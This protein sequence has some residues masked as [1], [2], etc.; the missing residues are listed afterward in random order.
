MDDMA[1]RG[2]KL[3]DIDG[4]SDIASLIFPPLTHTLTY[5]F[6]CVPL[7]CLP[8]F[9][10]LL[11]SLLHWL[12]LFGSGSLPFLFSSFIISHLPI[13]CLIMPLWALI[14]SYS[15]VFWLLCT[16]IACSTPL[17][18]SVPAAASVLV[19]THRHADSC[20]HSTTSNSHYF[21]WRTRLKDICQQTTTPQ[22]IDTSTYYMR[23]L[24]SV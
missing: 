7:I 12:I 17:F 13:P 24:K 23:R 11:F 4:Q 6:L 15:I 10:F 3:C 14:L 1:Y 18:G 19:C 21:A 9:F 20:N 8:N 16:S 2:H 22:N 5:T